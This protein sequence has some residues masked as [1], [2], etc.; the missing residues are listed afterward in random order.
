MRIVQKWSNG[1]E[2]LTKDSPKTI[3]AT[4]SHIGS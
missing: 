4:H 1:K 2:E 3:Y